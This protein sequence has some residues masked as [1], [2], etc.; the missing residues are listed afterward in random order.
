MDGF[1]SMLNTSIYTYIYEI[2]TC[3]QKKN[4]PKFFCSRGCSDVVNILKNSS[5][6]QKCLLNELKIIPSK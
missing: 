3:T 2:E 6:A 5:A 4:L 1:S